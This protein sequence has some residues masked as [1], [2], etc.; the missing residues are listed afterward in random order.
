MCRVASEGCP[1][2]L[3]EVQAA[4]DKVKDDMTHYYNQWCVSAP[5]YQRGDRMFLDASDI[6]TIRP[7]QKLAHK[8]LGPYT[9]LQRVARNTYK[10]ELPRSMSWLHPVFNVIKLILALADPIPED[11]QLRHL[12]QIWLMVRNTTSWRLCWIVGSAGIIS[13]TSSSGRV[14]VM[15]TTCG[16]PNS[17]WRQRI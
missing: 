5:E 13:N 14:T 9:V 2:T 6:K 4:L 12:S 16:F 8:F 10:L 7:S 1:Y 15:N 3:E 17:T 11:K